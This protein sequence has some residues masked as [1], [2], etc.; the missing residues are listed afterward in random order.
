MEPGPVH[1]RP[2]FHGEIVIIFMFN[3]TEDGCS[4]SRRKN[5]FSY[6]DLSSTWTPWCGCFYGVSLQ[7][8]S[9]KL[10]IYFTMFS[11]NI[12]KISGAINASFL[13]FQITIHFALLSKKCA[14]MSRQPF[15]ILQDTA[16]FVSFLPFLIVQISINFGFCVQQKHVEKMHAPIY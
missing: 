14:K 5:T 3:V 2:W 13:F 12:C 8:D 16:H 7:K 10:Y 9:S 6:H 15:L 1:H 11:N 4:F